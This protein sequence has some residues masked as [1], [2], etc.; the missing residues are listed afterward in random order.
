VGYDGADKRI[1]VVAALIG[2]GAVVDTGRIRTGVARPSPPPRNRQPGGLRRGER[3]QGTE[4]ADLWKKFEEV[5]GPAPS[6]WTSAPGRRPSSALSRG[7]RHTEHRAPGPPRRSAQGRRCWSIAAWASAA[8]WRSAS[9]AERLD[10]RVQPLRR[11]QDL[12]GRHRA[13]G[14]S[15]RHETRPGKVSPRPEPAAQRPP[16]TGA[17][18]PTGK[19]P[20]RPRA[21]SGGA[22]A[23][24]HA[25]ACGLSAPAPSCAEGRSR[26]GR[27]RLAGCC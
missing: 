7:R 19:A 12:A 26:Q 25:D 24:V 14:Q 17:R 6:F 23:V 10:R 18:S 9:C 27:R 20:A 3:A 1:D 22:R 13:A 2:K 8:T 16:R 4:R 11:L 21:W 5:A 15:R